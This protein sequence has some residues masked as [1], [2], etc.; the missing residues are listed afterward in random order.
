VLRAQWRWHVP[1][2]RESDSYPYGGGT[3]QATDSG[4]WT[5]SET[6]LTAQSRLRGTIVYALEKRNHL[7]NN[8]PLLMLNGQAFVTF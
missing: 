7:K 6:R 2:F 8:H 4:T 5:A 1:V 3:S